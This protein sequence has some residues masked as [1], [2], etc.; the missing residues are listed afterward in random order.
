MV[1]KLPRILVLFVLLECNL[2]VAQ[3]NLGQPT[4]GRNA[5]EKPT[6]FLVPVTDMGF[7]PD[8]QRILVY[9]AES[10]KLKLYKKDRQLSISV[11]KEGRP[12]ALVTLPKEVVQVNEIRAF[13]N[14]G[15]ISGMV[16]GS[17]S[18]VLIIELDRLAVVWQF[19]A[20]NPSISPNGQFIAFTKFFP[21]HFA[22]GTSDTN[23][24]FDLNSIANTRDTS[25]GDR[26]N[27]GTV[28]YPPN[29]T[30]REGDNTGVPANQS[31]HFLSQ[32]FFWAPDSQ[33]YVFADT[34]NEVLSLV[35][36]KVED[37][38]SVSVSTLPLSENDLCAPISKPRCQLTLSAANFV[39]GALV[40]RFRGV[41][42]DAVLDETLRIPYGK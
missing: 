16:N 4:S 20:Y 36:V 14:M 13:K 7:N 19:Y 9:R 17:V 24:L 41:G 3:A 32:D 38:R 42:V 30:N 28:A 12:S 1:P 27:V 8:N 21:P 2:A 40:A 26:V 5:P 22:E 10:L 18:E 35:V 25:L 33:N 37:I 29:A 23:L 11:E 6:T 34:Y 31:H 39:P 15:I